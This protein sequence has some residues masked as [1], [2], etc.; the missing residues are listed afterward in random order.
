[1]TRQRQRPDSSALH[2]MNCL[3]AAD[4]VLAA[5]NLSTTG[6][7]TSLNKPELEI[8]AS[9]RKAFSFSQISV[10]FSHRWHSATTKPGR[11]ISEAGVDGLLPR[12]G[13]LV[14]QVR[15]EKKLSP[16]RARTRA[17]EETLVE[18]RQLGLARLIWPI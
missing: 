5:L 12:P 18:L 2:G 4:C 6:L 7:T 11:R 16:H 3:K 13:N 8:G 1:M 15:E 17:T 10:R 9:R 14:M